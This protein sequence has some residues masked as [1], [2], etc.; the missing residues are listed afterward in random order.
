M[1]NYNVENPVNQST[2]HTVLNERNEYEELRKLK[3]FYDGV[4]CLR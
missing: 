1:N 4:Y 3:S 2:I